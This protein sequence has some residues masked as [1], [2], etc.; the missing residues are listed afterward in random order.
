MNLFDLVPVPNQ[1]A[2]DEQAPPATPSLT[3]DAA[4]DLFPLLQHEIKRRQWLLRPDLWA[5]ERMHAHLWSQQKRIMLAVRD[6]R[7]TEVLSCHGIGKS[8]DT[9]LIA[10]WWIDCHKPGDAIVVTTAPTFTQVRAILWKEIAHGHASAGL[11]GRVNQTEWFLPVMVN[12]K[13][14]D[15]MVAFG[16]KPSDYSPTAFQGIHAPYVL[17]LVD[18]ANGV[19][20]PLWDAIESIISNDQSKLLA[21][22]NPDDPHGE[23]YENSKPASGWHVIRISAFDSPNFTGE[24]IPESVSQQLI[25]HNYVEDRRRKWAPTWTWTDDSKTC[26]PPLGTDSQ[27]THPFWQSKILGVFPKTGG[28]G[29]L[30]PLEWIMNAQLRDLPSKGPHDLGLD[31]GASEHGDPS[32]LGER[33][34]PVFRVLWE[35]REP[36]TMKTTA[37]TLATAKERAALVPVSRIKVDYIG[38]GRG[39][40]D[41]AKETEYS[42]LIHPISVGEK[43]SDP[44]DEA[45]PAFADYL[46]E[47]WWHVRDL[48]E[49]GQIDLDPLDEELASQLLMVQW[50]PR[51][52][53]GKT[54]IKVFYGDGPSPNR[55]DA[56]M[57]TFAEP[58]ATASPEWYT[59]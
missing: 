27:D 35:Q 17:V 42:A 37:R 10:Q 56:L 20:G 26:V 12:G 15:K 28:L 8:F 16:R 5:A 41:R 50:E 44:V 48:F 11:P 21:I 33:I 7:K 59:W 52:A 34:G 46:S 40:V 43:P 55:A 18:E 25:G 1:Y 47:L 2:E 6:H 13:V 36:D 58:K 30:I 14:V 32:C 24:S 51:I 39:V 19:R 45:A 3:K 38:V 22:G 31:V 49:Q 53:N 4:L 9:A 54:V 57:L 29:S 23:F